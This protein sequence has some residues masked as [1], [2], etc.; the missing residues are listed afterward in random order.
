MSRGNRGTG[1]SVDVGK[2]ANT[3]IFDNLARHAWV[4]HGLMVVHIQDGRFPQEL[5]DALRQRL[6]FKHGRR[7]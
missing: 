2:N 1:Y 6:E 3:K 7:P 4:E 5:R